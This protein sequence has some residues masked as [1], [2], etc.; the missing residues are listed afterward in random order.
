MGHR[1]PVEDISMVTDIDTKGADKYRKLFK[2]LDAKKTGMKR[3]FSKEK[4][5]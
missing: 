4:F 5:V 1:N 2:E 3:T